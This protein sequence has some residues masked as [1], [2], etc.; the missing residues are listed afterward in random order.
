MIGFSSCNTTIYLVRHAEKLDA[1]S[2]SVLSPKGEQRALAL[3][4][5]LRNQDIDSI[6]TTDY[7]RTQ[8]TAQPLADALGKKITSYK[9]GTAFSEQLKNL[10][11]K[12]VLVIGHSN[13][14]PA[15]VMDL[16]NEKITIEED[17]FDNLYIIRI[18]RFLTTKIS[19]ESQTY[20]SPS[21]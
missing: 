17:D 19:M 8:L 3:R 20:G 15:I 13:T 2:N 9:P 7:K 6:Y 5:L 14:I 16:L 18:K 10:K 12:T 21:P 1:S 4:E 11:E